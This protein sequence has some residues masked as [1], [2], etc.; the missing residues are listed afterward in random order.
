M[1]HY[2]WSAMRAPAQSC[3]RFRLQALQIVHMEQHGWPGADIYTGTWLIND[4]SPD[5]SPTCLVVSQ[6]CLTMPDLGS[7]LTKPGLE[8]ISSLII[9]MYVQDEMVCWTR[10]G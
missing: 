2:G 5:L 8:M 6:N 9:A 1:G 10:P 3:A 4:Q 7:D